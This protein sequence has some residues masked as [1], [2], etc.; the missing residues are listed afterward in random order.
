MDREQGTGTVYLIGAGPGDPGL[1]TVRG[2]SRLIQAD[3]IVYDRLTHPKLLEYAQREAEKIYV[4]KASAHHSMTQDDIN[5]LLV[6]KAKAGLTVARLKGGDP[7]VFGRGGEEAEFCRLHGVPFEIVPGITSA[8]AAPAYAG[9]PVTH[10]DMASSFAVITG[11]ERDDKTESGTRAPG[12]AEQRRNWANI[13]HAADT[14]IFLMGVEALPEISARLIEHG[15]A[16]ETPVALVQWGTWTKQ[17]VVTGTLATI[18][19]ERERAQLTPPAVCVV[20]K[21][22]R[23]REYLRWFDNLKHRPLFAK[24]IVVTRAREDA[25]ALSHWLRERGAEPIE[26]PTIKIEPLADTSAIDDALLHLSRYAWIVFTSDKAVSAVYKRMDEFRLDGRAFAGVMVA[27]IGETTAQAVHGLL[28]VRADFVPSGSVAETF[29]AEFPDDDLT[30][31]RILLPRAEKAREVLPEEFAKRGATVD[32][33]PVYENVPDVGDVASIRAQLQ[34]GEIDAVTFAS[35]SSVR[36]FV[37]AL[38]EGEAV[39]LTELLGKAKLAAIGPVTAETL[40]EFGLTPHI[41]ATEHTIP[42]LVD[43]LEEG[44]RS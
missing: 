44:F 33:I 10:R 26:F 24:R 23:L 6:A 2:Q 7:F 31:K 22:V 35:S 16:P 34:A 5:R 13:A 40:L 30:G 17:Q 27:S 20:G 28:G 18:V 15:R 8:I 41:V 25:S 19:E 9:I 42:G 37:Q 29:A 21:V 3:V 1:I 36:N 38:T 11:H 39:S 14:L 4:G 32:A 43:A 12:D